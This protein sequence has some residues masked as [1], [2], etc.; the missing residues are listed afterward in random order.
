MVEEAYRLACDQVGPFTWSHRIVDDA[1]R[2]HSVMVV[3]ETTIVPAGEVTE[4][5]GDRDVVGA[6]GAM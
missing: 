1:G 3:G 6:C 5:G 2:V 4:G